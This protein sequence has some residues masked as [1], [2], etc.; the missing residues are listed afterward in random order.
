M[1]NT[2]IGY[3][4]SRM[5]LDEP[6]IQLYHEVINQ[7]DIDV[8]K[9]VRLR[10]GNLAISVN[11]IQLYSND[12]P[13][14]AEIQVSEKVLQELHIPADVILSIKRTGEQE[15]ALGPV[16]GILT[17]RHTYAKKRFRFYLNY[18]KMLKSGLL[19]VFSNQGVNPEKNTIKGYYFSSSVNTWIPADLPYP[20]AVIDRC[21]PNAYRTHEELEKYMGK[22][23]IF[24][25]KTMINKLDF[26]TAI[27]KD[28][29]LKNYLP[30]SRLCT[31]ASDI[32]YLL[33][34][35]GKIFIKPVTGM[36]GR[37]IVT[38]SLDSNGVKC[39]YM[40]KG[41]VLEKEMTN[42]C[43]F[44][45]LFETLVHPWRRYII[46]EAISIM[47]Y[48]GQPFCF[49]IM[50]CKNGNGQWLVPAIFTNAAIGNS[51]L[52][53][54]AA[55]ASIFVPLTNLFN[56]INSRLET[57][58]ENFIN[59]LVELAIKT[60]VALDERYGPLGELGLDVVVDQSG[61]LYLL[62]AN[63]N[64]GMVPKSHMIDFPGWASQVF[65]LPIAYAVYLAGY[66]E[67]NF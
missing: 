2:A 20:D 54:H 14:I 62:E 50:V 15:L 40:V 61:R 12:L 65:R 31:D 53:N 67:D 56:D 30:E 28:N 19:F 9:P 7:L 5:E 6:S 60:A 51:F 33:K 38:A 17:F 55:G 48:E 35:Y 27:Y 39:Q 34:K 32:E 64:P 24:N 47:E 66:E 59:S 16:I 26:Y 37:G 1:A 44:L 58:K 29:F 8:E 23:K 10:F 42:P 52:T 13:T 41:K 63:G 45:N 49:R 4:V 11:V 22:G 25:K 21:Y 57:T 46:Q 3:K 43:Q 18:Q 36:R